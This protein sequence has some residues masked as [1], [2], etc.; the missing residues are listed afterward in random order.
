MCSYCIVDL[1]LCFCVAKIRFSHDN[2]HIIE[3]YHFSVLDTY[4]IDTDMSKE[5]N[6]SDSWISDPL[7]SP[8]LKFCLMS[9]KRQR[10]YQSQMYSMW[11]WYICIR[12]Y[13]KTSPDKSCKGQ[14]ASTESKIN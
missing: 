9:G 14:E 5:T 10:Y 11:W 2:A 13:G 7:F 12:Q 3:L 8:W 1:R 4:S 6:F